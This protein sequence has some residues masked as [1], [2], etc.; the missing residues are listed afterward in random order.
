MSKEKQTFLDT[1]DEKAKNFL[2]SINA[3]R[4][5]FN[6]TKLAAET[7][8]EVKTADGKVIKYTGDELA[9]GAVCTLVTDAGET[10][11]PEGDIVLEDGRTLKVGKDS[12]VSEI[13]EKPADDTE[14]KM[15]K[16]KKALEDLITKFAA[17]TTE[18][19][20]AN[21]EVM[22]KALMNYNFSYDLSQ[23]AKEQAIA[24]FTTL[25]KEKGILSSTEGKEIAK[26]HNASLAKIK[27]LE[28]AL[29]K[30]T[31]F[32]LEL[33]ETVAKFMA[34]PTDT[35]IEAGKGGGGAADDFKELSEDEYKNL[36]S[37]KKHKYDKA[38]REY[39]FNKKA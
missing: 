32:N 28:I 35:P 5:A 36:S 23:G 9:V 22:C 4:I 27:D 19:R 13:V 21:L 10:P 12:K 6:K 15:K 20:I 29:E 17:G 26:A 8:K 18:E 37:F 2:A 3:A 34:L 39:N 11:A 33:A 16:E 38:L 25:S 1:L 14:A 24:A 31:E 7:T 30:Q